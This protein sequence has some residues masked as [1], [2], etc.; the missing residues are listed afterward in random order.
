[1]AKDTINRGLSSSSSSL[2]LA[3]CSCVTIGELP[4]TPDL[5]EI[6][7]FVSEDAR[8]MN[9]VI[10]F[11][12][13]DLD[14]NHGRFPLLL[15]SWT[16]DEWKRITDLSQAIAEP[17][18]KAW[19]TTYLENHDQARSVSRFGSDETPELRVASAKMLAT[20]LLTLTGTPIIYQGGR[21]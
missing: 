21:T 7:S 8:Q 20:Y 12:L 2:F 9:M 17:A 18:N 19:V 5:G 3:A 14:H 10:Q 15:E 1:M 6:L 4:H 11:D 13:A 16:L